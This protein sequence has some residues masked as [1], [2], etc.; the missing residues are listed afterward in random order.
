MKRVISVDGD[1]EVQLD[2]KSRETLKHEVKSGGD[3]KMYY[4]HPSDYRWSGWYYITA[5]LRSGGN[6]S[7]A[8]ATR[9]TAEE[10]FEEYVQ[11]IGRGA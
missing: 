4:C 5:S 11:K 2:S 3:A 9:S 6:M 10:T 1:K 8:T 7:T